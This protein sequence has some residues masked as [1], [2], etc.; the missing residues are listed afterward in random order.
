MNNKD[1]NH[2]HAKRI[3]IKIG[4]R[5]HLGEERWVGAL[6][7]FDEIACA[8]IYREDNWNVEDPRIKVYELE[9]NKANYFLSGLLLRTRTK[10]Y[11]WIVN[12]ILILLMRASNRKWITSIKK[13]NADFALCSYGDYDRSDLVYLIVKNA[14]S[15]KTVRSY[16]ETRVGYNF[17][18]HETLKSIENICLYDEEL[19]KFLE[20]KYGNHLFEKKNLLI[21]PDENALPK[22]IL[23]K[24]VYQEKLSQNDGR[25]HI[26]ILSYRV[27]SA[28]NRERDQGR[29]YYIDTITQMIK[30]GLCVHLHCAQYNDF[31]GVNKYAELKDKKPDQ[32]FMEKPLNMK[33]DSTADQWVSSCEILSRYDF[34]LMHNIDDNSTVSEFDK[35]NIPHRFFAYEAAHV[36]PI[37][38]RGSNIVLEKRFKSEKCGVVVDDISDL[39]SVDISD[40]HYVNP[41]YEDYL[42][43]IIKM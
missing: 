37:I 7:A 22:C 42:D 36:A 43:S 23:D 11:L 27:D 13:I 9:N 35:I 29:Y 30:A 10:R 34:G 1:E 6:N 31:N 20:K 16:K 25:K 39:N 41:T 8:C 12:W 33:R 38:L 21:G 2:S 40:I 14:I 4:G 19:Q 28:P 32:F 17:L 24:I 3:M 18:E 15:C 26:V 5:K